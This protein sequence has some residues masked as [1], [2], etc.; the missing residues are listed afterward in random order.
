MIPEFHRAQTQFTLVRCQ[1]QVVAQ[2]FFQNLPMVGRFAGQKFLPVVWSS[3]QKLAKVIDWRFW[4]GRD[5]RRRG[6]P[7]VSGWSLR[8]RPTPWQR[9]EPASPDPPFNPITSHGPR[10]T[11]STRRTTL[12]PPL[13]RFDPIAGWH[14]NPATPSDRTGQRPLPTRRT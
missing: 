3:R 12:R 6:R 5:W 2:A 14:Q 9:Y 8:Q 1:G 13:A 7:C 10:L 4:G 11:G